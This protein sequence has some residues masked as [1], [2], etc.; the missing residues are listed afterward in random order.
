MLL[1]SL[2]KANIVK[3]DEV[4]HFV[5][6]L[7][8]HY[9]DTL[10]IKAFSLN[11]HFLNKQYRD[12]NYWD[13]KMP[14]RAMSI[15]TVE[16]D[17]EKKHYYDND[18]LYFPGGLLFDRVQFQNDTQAYYYE[19]SGAFLGKAVIK[20]NMNRF[21]T[22]T[23]YLV[24][25]LDFMAVRPLLEEHSSKKAITLIKDKKSQTTLVTHTLPSGD[26]IDYKFK[27]Q[28]LQLISVNYKPLN[29]YF[30]YH[31]YQTTR[32]ITY[33]RV[34]HQHYNGATVPQYITYN[35]SF[36][37]LDQVDPNRLK[38]PQGYNQELPRGDGKLFSSLLSKDLYLVTDSAG[39]RNSL[40]KVKDDKIM[41]FGVS[42]SADLAEKI[43]SFIAKEFPNKTLKSVH[44]THPHGDEISGLNVYAKH[45]IEI[46]A[47]KYTIAG[48]KAHKAFS[49]DI[50]NFKFR[51]LENE[52][53]ISGAK[54]Y[55]LETMHAKRQSFVHF[56]D[57]GI[58]FQSD[59]LHI[60]FDNT[61]P[62]VIPNYTRTFVDFV[63]NNKLKLNRVVSQYGNNNITVEVMNKA[64][65]AL[66]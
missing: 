32:G 66:M 9:Q 34:V 6:K 13:F 59:F 12:K 37:I 28:P 50:E 15:R 62:K 3:A 60:P 49:N 29:G 24:M 11:H 41:A 45:G 1:L 65:D 18:I 56:D 5:N 46:L 23:N 30:E 8:D 53:S 40:L 58:I 38:L 27:N 33:A 31:D 22:V 21:D 52:Q 16:V 43:I 25:K 7:K 44:I 61:I 2:F 54:F 10:P 47:D 48:I 64:Y 35:D 19:K 4:Q 14:N 20:Q 51:I 57:A 42:G 17:L 26:T 39:R 63:R 36:N 55:I